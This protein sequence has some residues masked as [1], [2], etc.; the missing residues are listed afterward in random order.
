[1][2]NRYG[3]EDS[4][5]VPYRSARKITTSSA[6]LDSFF[7]EKVRPKLRSGFEIQ[8]KNSDPTNSK[9]LIHNSVRIICNFRD[10]GC[11]LPTYFISDF[12]FR[13]LCGSSTLVAC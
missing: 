8:K 7:A 2:K 6:V 4:Q 1:M 9:L 12:S 13:S 5:P 11:L 3:L 10:M